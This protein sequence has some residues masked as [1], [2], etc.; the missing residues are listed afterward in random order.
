MIIYDYFSSVFCI[1]T[2]KEGLVVEISKVSQPLEKLLPLCKDGR[3]CQNK[4]FIDVINI[5]NVKV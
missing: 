3:K 4:F 2:K 1:V 5:K